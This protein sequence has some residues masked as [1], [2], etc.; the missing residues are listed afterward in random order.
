MLHIEVFRAVWS[1]LRQRLTDQ[2]VQDDG[3]VSVEQVII[4]AGLVTVT[5]VAIAALI[6][7]VTKYAGKI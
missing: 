5:V 3:S 4:T 7:G 1:T 2:R 6:A